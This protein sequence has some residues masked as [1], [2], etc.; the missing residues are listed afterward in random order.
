MK[1]LLLSLALLLAVSACTASSGPA[2]SP[3]APEIKTIGIVSAIGETVIYQRVGGVPSHTETTW[4]DTLSWQLDDYVAETIKARLAPR[5]NIAPVDADPAALRRPRHADDALTF[6]P[7]PSVADR[8]RTALKPGTPP[9]DA[10][11][12]VMAESDK[13]FIG[14]TNHRLTGLAIYRR[15]GSGLQIYAV[16]NMF[17]VDAHSFKII[18]SAPLR[19]ERD[20]MF[21]GAVSTVE[22]PYRPLDRSLQ[23][24]TRWDQFTET[25]RILIDVAFKNLL[26]DTLEYTLRD[27]KLAP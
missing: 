22:R 3:A 5:Y 13:D 7:G 25:D 27:M 17:L 1:K 8:L 24:D 26:R 18:A 4:G 12:V 20:R 2:A 19:L 14:G 6:E 21:G 15:A 10:Y 9:V 23:R 16:C 11:L